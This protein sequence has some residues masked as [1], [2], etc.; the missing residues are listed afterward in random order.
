MSELNAE[1]AAARDATNWAKAVSRLDVSEMPDEA[2]NL[3]SGKRL[4][5]PIQGFGKMWQK[6]YQAALPS[7]TVSA[8][9]LIS[10][11]KQNFP[12]FWPDGNRFYA[13]LTGIAPV[14][15]VM[16]PGSRA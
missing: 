4:A 9:D 15:S 3:V 11:W 5:G 8:Q 6:T 13:P 14:E 1:Q 10:T 7:A 16:F 2:V 12:S